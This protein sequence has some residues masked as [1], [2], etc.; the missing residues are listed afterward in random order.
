MADIVG[1]PPGFMTTLSPSSWLGFQCQAWFP[2]GWVGLES[3]WLA[4]GYGQGMCAT[5][6]PLRI[7]CHPSHCFSSQASYLGTGTMNASSHRGDL[8]VGPAWILWALVSDMYGVFCNMNLSLTSGR[9]P[10]ETAIVNNVLGVSWIIPTN[11][12]SGGFSCLVLLL[13]FESLG[14]SVGGGEH[15]QPM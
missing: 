15:C 2:F 1:S 5:V 14:L 12:S 10:K 6:V 8:Q 9:Q 3:H 11:N 7:L 13:S 4:L